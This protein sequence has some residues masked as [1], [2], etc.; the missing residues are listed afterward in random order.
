KQWLLKFQRK[1]HQCLRCL[2]AEWVE[3]ISKLL[4]HRSNKETGL[5]CPFFFMLFH[6][7]QPVNLVI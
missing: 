2:L 7:F 5:L 6:V 1:I 4:F 3:W